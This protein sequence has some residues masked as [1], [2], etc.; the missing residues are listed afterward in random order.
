MVYLETERLSLRNLELSDAES[1]SGYRND[2]ACRRYQRWEAFTLPDV[3]AYIEKFQSDVFLSDRQEQHFGIAQRNSLELVGE[4]AYF[5]KPGV[6]FTLGIT[7]APRFQRNGYACEMLREVIR[8]VREKYP[9]LDIVALIDK[10]NRK[11]LCLFE[12]LGFRQEC[13]ADSI[14]SFVYVLSA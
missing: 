5:Y 2:E 3:E 1:I 11:S 4:L 14:A 8:S 10:D 9:T 12:K 13:Y 6:L 7:V